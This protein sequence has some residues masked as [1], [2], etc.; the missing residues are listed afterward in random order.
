MPCTVISQVVLLG[1]SHIPVLLLRP[2]HDPPHYS[3]SDNYS[4]CY[5]GWLQSLPAPVDS[6]GLTCGHYKCST[7]PLHHTTPGQYEV[8]HCG[9]GGMVAWQYC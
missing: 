1:I 8:S 4:R 9:I 2:D 3:E 7:A 5:T 6:H